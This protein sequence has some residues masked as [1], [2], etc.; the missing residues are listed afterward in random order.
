MPER[1]RIAIYW[2]ASCGGCEESV[3]DLAEDLLGVLDAVQIV[4]WPVALDAKRADV[5]A[6]PDGSLLASLINGAVRTSEQ[7]EM[8][9][10]LR[11]KSQ[12]VIAYGACAQLGGIPGLANQFER[13]RILQDAYGDAPSVQNPEGTR[14]LPRFRDNGRTATLP[15][16]HRRVRTLAQVVPV[17]YTLPG[18]PPTPKLL[19]RA[20]AALLS[21]ALPPA[22]SVLAPDTALCEECPRRD[23]KPADL[24]FTAFARPH[25]TV[26]DPAR[27]LLAQGL[28]CLG[29]ATRGGCEALCLKGN[30]PCT[31]CFGPTSRVRDQGAKALSAL[32]SSVSATAE[33]EMD[34]VLA[35]I[36]DPVGTFYRYGL[37]GSLLRGRR[38][39]PA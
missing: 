7:D 27:C 34:R 29:P 24:H 10:L 12:R 6:L 14:P 3:V 35:T 26:V 15:E 33:A 9:R 30:M 39:G 4:F 32:C 23:S 21:G 37:A 28:L 2:A 25:R 38:M 20:L 17:D 5:E 1:P 22:G 8:V 11:R 19:G 36:P 16:L 13:D 31:G 18:C